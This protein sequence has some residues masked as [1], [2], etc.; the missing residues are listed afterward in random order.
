M[1]IT[2]TNNFVWEDGMSD[3]RDLATLCKEIDTL[4][5]EVDRLSARGDDY[6]QLF[7]FWLNQATLIRRERDEAR[8][9]S[10][11]SF[12]NIIAL[13]TTGIASAPRHK[14]HEH[15]NGRGWDCFKDEIAILKAE[16]AKQ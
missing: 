7:T 8:C 16:S 11:I 4:T 10:C 6:K 2:D 5:A 9:L 13:V 3:L 14:Y 1:D 15:A 12:E